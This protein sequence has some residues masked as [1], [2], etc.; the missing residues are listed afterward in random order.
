M[1]SA[2]PV[3]DRIRIIPRTD[4]FLDR[5][6]GN[7][8]EVFFDKES[9]SLRLYDGDFQGGFT[10]L[11]NQNLQNN[12]TDSGVAIVEYTVT[13]GTDPEGIESGNKYFING[14]YKPKLNFVVG[15]TY[16]FN[17][18]DQTNEYFPN[19]EGGANN[20]HP[21][22]FS[23]DNLNGVLGGGT[24][25]TLGV[26]YKLDGDIVD[27]QTY[28]DKFAGATQRSVQ[29]TV[30]STTP[31]T[32]YYWCTYHTG[33][34]NEVTTAQPGSGGG[35]ASISV[36]DTAPESPSSGA[37]WYNSTS[38]VLYVYVE[39][40]DS[41]QWVQ[42]TAPFPNITSILDLGISDGTNGQV[43]TTDGAGGF[44]FEDA[45]D[46]DSWNDLLDKPTTIAGFGITDAQELLVS[47]TNIKTINGTS[48][49]GAG[50]IVITGSGTT[51]SIEFSGT[52]ID[53]DDSSGIVFTPA[54]TMSSDL[55]VENGLFVNNDLVVSGAIQSEGSGIPEVFSDNEI[56]LTAGTRVIVNQGPLKMATFTT[57]E[58]D[59]L[60]A[61]NGDIIYNTTTNK[62]Q[63]Y[64]NGAWANLI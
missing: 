60:S 56:F 61:Q 7:S 47:G 33:M 62:F 35:S 58:R 6:F 59:L 34:G 57:T 23:S 39:D 51:G 44:T 15:Y 48:I 38:G 28:D 43:L 53:S 50:N 3:V 24:T 20:Q 32:L 27:R 25:Y 29:I 16:I 12:L 19:P 37:I 63:G 22:N 42:P 8:G 64:E 9:N 1:S 26:V 17:Q 36:S 52:T 18:N 54:V 4:D 10:V 30:F 13:V 2:A 41:Q 40:A 49:M 31:T 21:L 55:T 14:V 5:N 11:T 46:T 45:S